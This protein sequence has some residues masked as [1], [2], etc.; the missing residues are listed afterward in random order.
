M[1]TDG[2]DLDALLKRLHLPTVRRLYPEYCARAAAESWSH[3]DLLALLFAEE[4]AHRNDTRIQKSA[5]QANFPFQKSVETFDFVFQSTLGRQRLGPY[6]APELI[7]EGRCLILSGRPGRGKTHLAVAI[8]YRAIQN[9]FTARFVGAGELIDALGAASREGR[10]REA[11]ADWVEPHVLVIDE[12]GY[13]AHAAD[14]AN[15]LFGVVDQ[16]YLA[17]KPMI[18]TT[19]KKL[20]AWGK[21]LHDPDLAEV[22]LD[23]VL[24]RGEH[25]VLGGPSW[26]T[27]HLDPETLGTDPA[28]DPE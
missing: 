1:S 21:V 6:L 28:E 15:V 23:R 9:G 17:K 18:F 2:I 22:I 16:R 7:S 8:G 11:T 13:L 26:R 19:N 27:K 3:R 10:L 14:A 4:V 12:V 25:L 20:R 24:E 5:R